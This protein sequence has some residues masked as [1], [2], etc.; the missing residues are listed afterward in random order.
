MTA[1][2]REARA[3][4]VLAEELANAGYSRPQIAD[5][6]NISMAI[7]SG[8][9]LRAITR[10]LQP[11]PADT[12][13]SCSPYCD[14]PACVKEQ[15]D[16]MRDAT[17]G[18]GAVEAVARAVLQAT[19]PEG[20]CALWEWLRDNQFTTDERQ[21]FG[22]KIARAAIAAMPASMNELSGNSGQLPAKADEVLAVAGEIQAKADH[23]IYVVPRATLATWAARLRAAVKP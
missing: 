16:H 22:M 15:R 13:H 17:A 4:E 1:A 19:D 5:A 2:D 7:M 3:R 10:A 12:I 8:V 6:V 23:D 9:A 21:V 11:Q 14:L 18:E 20:V